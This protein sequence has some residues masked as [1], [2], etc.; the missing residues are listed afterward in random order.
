MS[1]KELLRSA[2]DSVLLTAVKSHKKIKQCIVLTGSYFNS[3][4]KL[5]Q[6]TQRLQFVQYNI[7]LIKFVTAATFFNKSYEGINKK[8]IR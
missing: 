6:R 5:A 8:F 4:T 3:L 2:L 1:E 7:N